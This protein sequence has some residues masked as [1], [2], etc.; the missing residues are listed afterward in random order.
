MD[1]LEK[2]GKF[3]VHTTKIHTNSKSSDEM[4]TVVEPRMAENMGKFHKHG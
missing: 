4:A 1:T 3:D 2:T